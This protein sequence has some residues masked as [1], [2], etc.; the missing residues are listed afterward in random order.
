[1]TPTPYTIELPDFQGPLDLL[2]RLIEQEELDITRI[3]LAYVTDQYL[4]YLALLQAI[5]PDD[6]TD[7][8]VIAARLILIKSEM[9]LPR[10]PP[11]AATEED[12]E[13]VG[14]DLATQLRL[15]KQF[16]EVAA[17]LQ[18]REAAGQRSFVRSGPPPKIEAKLPAGQ[19]NIEKLL[20]A[21]RRALAVKPPQ[22]D[23]DQVVSR[24]L[25]T[26]GRQMAQIR[27]GLRAGTPL[28]FRQLLSPTP[29]RIELI[30]TLLAVLELLK[31]QAITVEQATL[32]GE[33]I[34]RQDRHFL[35]MTEAEWEELTGLTEVS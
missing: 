19:G 17:H 27:Q 34:L 9:L 22:P 24:E 20:Q 30:V 6:L 1:M 7:F 18:A 8:L 31:R 5:N 29:G 4:A 10:P 3:A 15:Y 25:V 14:N 28:S 35:E 33:I 13:D 16:K 26:I 11:I 2:L 32:F 23:V 12:E 21:A